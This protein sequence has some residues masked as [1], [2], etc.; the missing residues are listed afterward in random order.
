MRIDPPARSIPARRRA[1]LGTA[2]LATLAGVVAWALATP[3]AADPKLALAAP[4][5]V[6]AATVCLRWPAEGVIGVLALTGFSGSLPAFT[7]I[8]GEPVVDLLLLGLWAGAIWGHLSGT[9]RGIAWLWPGVVA[10]GLYLGLTAI[11]IAAAPDPSLGLTSFRI[12]AWYM[13]AMLLVAYAPWPAATYR[14]IARGAVLVTL[15][16]GSYA[17]LRKLTGSATAEQSH[18]IEILN[19]DRK[20][21]LRFFGSLVSA[22]ALAAW[23]A[24]AGTFCF[25]IALG[26]RGGWRA[27]AAVAA[28]LCLVAVIASEI[29]TGLA[30]IAV[31]CILVLVL[32]QLALGPAGFRPATGLVMVV[33]LAVAGVGGFV[34]LAGD[35]PDA[36]RRYEAIL[37]PGDDYAYSVR[38]TRWEN[39]IAEAEEHPFG[40]G[41]GTAGG[42][43]VRDGRARTIGTTSFDSSY[44]KI[45]LEQGLAVMVF[46]IIALAL[47]LAGLARRALTE[48]DRERASLAIGGAGVLAAMLV[49]FYFGLYIEGLAA[50]TGWILVGVGLAQ[51]SE[52][53]RVRRPSPGRRGPSPP[54]VARG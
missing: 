41:L 46:F 53:P 52:L 37:S 11:E 29:R 4:A 3:L 30:A 1:T 6:V 45:A 5:F 13:L 36:G 25:A 26:L 19:P 18:A 35:S 33:A 8:G 21:E 23:S 7:G 28:S 38:L 17:L 40:S 43:A 42:A 22:Q 15:A 44:L 39:V 24:S 51:F 47:L 12:G 20:E 50:L 34:A 48:P 31:G 54:P 32:S 49:L 27:A 2:A 10:C 9:G 16:V 14:R